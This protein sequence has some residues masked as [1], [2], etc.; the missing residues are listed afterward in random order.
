MKGRRGGK[1]TRTVRIAEEA[2]ER[3][4]K[5]ALEGELDRLEGDVRLEVTGSVVVE[6][7]NG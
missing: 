3:K 4:R 2:R 6:T 5:N 1:K 7:E